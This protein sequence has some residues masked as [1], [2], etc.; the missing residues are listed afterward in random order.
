MTL[1]AKA[2]EQAKPKDTPYKLAD[3]AGLYLYVAPTGLKSW[4]A[5]YAAGGK[6]RT[7]TY[8]QWPALSLA[9]A[10]IANAQA[11]AEKAVVALTPSSKVPTFAEITQSWLAVKLPGLSNA[12]HKGQVAGTIERWV[13]PR[14]GALPVDKLPRNLLVEVVTAIPRDPG[15][16]G[17]DRIETAHLVAGRIGAVLD[18]AVDRGVIQHHNGAGLVR[19][20]PPRSPVTHMPSIAPEA[21]GRLS[22]AL[23]SYPEPVTRLGLRLLLLLFV[24]T[25]EL[26]AMEWGEIVEDGAVWVVPAEKMKRRVPHVVPLCAQARAVLDRLRAINGNCQYVLASPLERRAPIS[27]NTMLFALYRL[28][29]KGGMTGHGF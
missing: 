6:Q 20:L 11:K 12:K 2:V 21:A 5:N 27:E 17:D 10:R 24:R 14:I 13:L 22:V 16:Y 7:R 4:R 25:G 26:R 18:H 23:D 29:Y 9:Q 3:G 1:T 8:G 19:V 15:E 28:G